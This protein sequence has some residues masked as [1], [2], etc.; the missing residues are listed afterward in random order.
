MKL[1]KIISS[2]ILFITST[3]EAGPIEYVCEDKFFTNGVK[4]ESWKV[5]LDVTLSPKVFHY[6]SFDGGRKKLTGFKN[7]P[8]AVNFFNRSMNNQKDAAQV[9][10]AFQKEIDDDFATVHVYGATGGVRAGD[11]IEVFWPEWE[12]YFCYRKGSEKDKVM[13]KL[14]NDFNAHL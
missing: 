4:A 1:K 9:I 2:A 6:I 11:V 13:E 12:P 14:R 3:A 10:A 5:I 7:N 8:M